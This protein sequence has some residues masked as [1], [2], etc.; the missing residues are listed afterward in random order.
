MGCVKVEARSLQC[1]CDQTCD[2]PTGEG[3]GLHSVATQKRVLGRSKSGRT[4]ILPVP[5]Q[6]HAQF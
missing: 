1:D 6:T 5:K 3:G 4:A 2:F